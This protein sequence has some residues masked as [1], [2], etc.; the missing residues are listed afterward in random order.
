VA[1]PALRADGRKRACGTRVASRH[2]RLSS[3]T[4]A[5]KMKFCYLD[6]SGTGSEPVA[7]VA[8]I[9]VDSQR[10]HVTKGEWDSLLVHLS[11][12]VGR[13]LDELHTKDFYPGNGPF[14]VLDGPKRALYISAIIEWLC[15][16]KHD[17]V[18]S[19]VNKDA[20]SQTLNSGR[21][22]SGLATPWLC[23]AFH[24]VLALQRA[25]QTQEKTKGHTVLVF[26]HKGQ[27]QGPLT[28]LVL[29]PPSWSDEYYDRAKKQS[30]LDQIIDAPHFADSRHIPLLQLAD[31]LAYFLRR[32]VE[33][34]EKLV[35]TKYTEE[36]ERV[37][38]WIKMLSKRCIGLAHIYPSKGR[39]SIADFF[40]QHC[41]QSLRRLGG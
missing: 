26:D 36:Q 39:G 37:A 12:L 15:E 13:E 38:G 40:F 5:P 28:D 10:M 16:R 7:V 29:R 17:F 19:A 25:H 23:G 22:P 33:I 18:F 14:R 1:E 2:G 9:V 32:F 8:G 3:A 11:K 4:L 21:V 41:P 35:S 34:E 31:F 27:E 20:F 6:E 24:S 30:P